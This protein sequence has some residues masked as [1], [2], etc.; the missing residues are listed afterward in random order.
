MS[1]KSTGRSYRISRVRKKHEEVL[2][3][4]ISRVHKKDRVVLQDFP[5]P[6][7]AQGGL[8][9]FPVS[10]KSTGRCYRNSRVHR[11]YRI[12]RVHK[13]HR[14][15]LQGFPCPQ[16]AQGG[17]TG[18]P[19]STKST[20]RS[21]RISRST[22]FTGR[23]YRISR[24]HKK[25]KA[26][27]GL[28]GFSGHRK[29][30]GNPVGLTGISRVHKK[31]TGNPVRP[32]RAFCGHGKSSLCTNPVRPPCPFCGRGKSCNVR[33]PRA[34]LD[35]DFL[36]STKSTGR[37]CTDFPCFST[38]STGRSYSSKKK[39]GEVVH[40]FSCPQKARGVVQDFPCPQKVRGGRFPVSRKST[41]RSYTGFPMPTKGTGMSYRISRVRKRH[42]EVLQD[43]PCPQKAQ[44]GLTGF[45][46]S[47]KSMGRC[48]RISR[49]RKKHGKVLQDFLC[50][51]K[52]RGG[53]TGFPVST[54]STGEVLMNPAAFLYFFALIESSLF[55]SSLGG[56]AAPPHMI[57]CNIWLKAILFQS[58]SHSTHG[59]LIQGLQTAL[60]V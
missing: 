4:R 27:G 9:G 25:Q 22:N 28:T 48:Y 1:T 36:V 20:G 5:C 35:T 13:K 45:P 7:E 59:T 30:W 40:E 14:E 3:Y 43:F 52:A 16:K 39:H 29:S 53:R 33:P 26:R 44:G 31:H 11:S 50:P 19:V 34:F 18:F 8:T 57:S 17:L 2:H 24:V 10:T 60:H 15:V 51:Q 21:Y 37:S 12:S 38:K 56:A 6:Q 47:T 49:V 54:E 41:G 32:P 46:V 23:S 42:R 58:C 55:Q